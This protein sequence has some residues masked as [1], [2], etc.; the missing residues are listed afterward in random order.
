[1]DRGMLGWLSDMRGIKAARD[2]KM[3]SLS[4]HFL[5]ALLLWL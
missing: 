2:L 1:M 4:G 5:S 3:L